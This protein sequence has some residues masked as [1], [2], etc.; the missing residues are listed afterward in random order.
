MSFGDASAC[1]VADPPEPGSSAR[2]RGD[3]LGQITAREA[4]ITN[5][6]RISSI[7]IEWQRRQGAIPAANAFAIMLFKRVDNQGADILGLVL[8]GLAIERGKLVSHQTA[9]ARR[10]GDILLAPCH[11]ADD[12]GIMARAVVV[13]P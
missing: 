8:V 11:I 10:Y 1:A 7:R 4:T 2:A 5:N 9:T 3:R 12:A 13:R 6:T